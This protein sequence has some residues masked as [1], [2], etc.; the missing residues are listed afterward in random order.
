VRVHTDVRSAEI[1]DNLNARAF[2]LGNNIA[3]GS[4]EYQPGTLI[5]NALIAHELAHVVQQG[6]GSAEAAPMQKGE[7]ETDLREEEGGYVGGGRDGFALGQD[8]ACAERDYTKHQAAIK[9]RAAI[10]SLP[11]DC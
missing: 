4:G 2:T 10:A 3:F 6:G 1:S 7:T 11:E 9:I 5:G 8:K